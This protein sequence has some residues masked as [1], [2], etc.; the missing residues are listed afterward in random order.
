MEEDVELDDEPFFEGENGPAT[1]EMAGMGDGPTLSLADIHATRSPSL[2]RD[3][4]TVAD[5]PKSPRFSVL[6]FDE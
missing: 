3:V 4:S 5:I 1:P 6:S 2:D